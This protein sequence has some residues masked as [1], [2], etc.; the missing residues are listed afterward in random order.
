MGLKYLSIDIET[1]GLD[2]ENDRILEIAAVIEDTDKQLDFDEI[3]KYKAILN[4]NRI[5]GS[6]YAL[7]LNTRILEILAKIPKHI[8]GDTFQQKS[9]YLKKH[10]IILPQDFAL[11]FYCFLESNG[12]K[13]DNGQIKIIVAGKNFGAFDKQFL[14]KLPNLKKYI[15]FGHRTIDPANLYIDFE[16]DMEIP[17][18]NT[19]LERAQITDEVT[20]NA[21]LD[22]WDVVRVMRKK[23]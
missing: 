10:N 11:S 7:S 5:S 9:N 2:S 12:Y 20:H 23:Y 15:D 22:A 13:A 3:P 19:C 16:H 14:E 6:A 4:Y 8:D 1:S 17:S 18:L 21:L